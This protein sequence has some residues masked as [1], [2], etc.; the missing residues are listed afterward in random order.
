M[1]TSITFAIITDIHSNLESLKESI[2][3]IKSN[4][5]VDKIICLGDCFSL[6]PD[7]EGTARAAARHAR[8]GRAVPDADD[9]H[10]ADVAH[11]Q[12]HLVPPWASLLVIIGLI[13]I[14][15]AASLLFPGTKKKEVKEHADTS[16]PDE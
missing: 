7:P 2:K 8:P 15:V 5:K 11:A 14:S 13:S 6:G 10:R 9:L 1:K 4:P 3:I 12:G 16:F